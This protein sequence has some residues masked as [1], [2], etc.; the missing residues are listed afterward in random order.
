MDEALPV[1]L[2]EFFAMLFRLEK[3]YGAPISGGLQIG[4]QFPFGHY[5]YP[6]RGG[7]R[8]AFRMMQI[9]RESPAKH[10]SLFESYG[11]ASLVLL[12]ELIEMDG[13][14]LCSC[15]LSVLYADRTDLLEGSI[16]PFQWPDGA[17]VLE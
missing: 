2:P 8:D 17:Y 14:E 10:V 3:E 4:D 13:R 12:R 9:L 11:Y 1:Y 7:G 15:V 16:A 6:L 5:H